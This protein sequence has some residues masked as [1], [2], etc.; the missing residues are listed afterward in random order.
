MNELREL[1]AR[2][3]TCDVCGSVE[4]VV[5]ATIYQDETGELQALFGSA[6]D[7]CTNCDAMRIDDGVLAPQV[8]QEGKD[9]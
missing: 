7:H 9:D 3:F 8:P 2:T 5:P 1:N 6:A 4:R